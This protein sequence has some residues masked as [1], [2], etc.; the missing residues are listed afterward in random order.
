MPIPAQHL[1]DELPA[2]TPDLRRFLE[3]QWL[4]RR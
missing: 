4:T 2:T 3:Q 1:Q